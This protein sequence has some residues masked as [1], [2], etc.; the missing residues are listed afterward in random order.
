MVSDSCVIFGAITIFG[1]GTW[2]ITPE[3]RWLPAARLGKIR[4]LEADFEDERH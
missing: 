4:Q 3:D 2:W 1:I